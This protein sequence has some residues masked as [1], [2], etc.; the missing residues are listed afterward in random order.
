MK[1]R[2]KSEIGKITKQKIANQNSKKRK[3]ERKRV[4][5]KNSKKEKNTKNKHNIGAF[6][7]TLSV[8]I[9]AYWGC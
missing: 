9:F 4:T 7:I 6:V 8:S 1:Q 3:K 2:I 5:V